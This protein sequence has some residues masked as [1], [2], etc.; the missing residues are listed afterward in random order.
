[1]TDTTD[2]PADQLRPAR[3]P[4]GRRYAVRTLL[5]LAT[6]VAVLSIVSVWANRQLLNADNWADTSTQLLADPAVKTAVSGYLIDQVYANVDVSAELARALPP[7]LK[8]LAG[9]ASGGLQN[10]AQQVTEKALGRPRVQ[11]AWKTANRLAAERFVAIAEGKSRLVTISGQTVY[12]DLGALVTQDGQRLGL[13]ASL[14]A[15]IP[16]GAGRIA[17]VNSRQASAVQDATAALRGL[18]VVLPLA[19]VLLLVL[20]VALARGRRRETL[21]A[22]GWCLV[23]AG[24]LVLVARTVAGQR[25]VDSLARTDAVVPAAQATWTIATSM[26][27]DI[28]WATIVIGIP[29]VIAAWIAGP[30]RSAH[31]LRRAA[32]PWLRERPDVTYGVAA[33]LLLLVIAWG[34]IPATRMVIPVLVMIALVA[35]GVTMLRR[36]VA[37]EFPGATV[38]GAQTAWHDR[39]AHARHAVREG[40]PRRR[41]TSVGGADGRAGNGAAPAGVAPVPVVSPAERI[42]LL[43][44]LTTLHERGVLTDAELATEKAA[45]LHPGDGTG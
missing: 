26:L 6:I 13:P 16:P 39:F 44:R 27:H 21:R 32:A 38:A 10:L 43:E 11:Q 23:L 15:K 8:P 4:R 25:V 37:L 3:L 20:A 42:A 36:Q 45:L 5:V 34:P 19:G 14:T 33:A 17:I 41:P 28:A 29:L 24:V 9:P 7:R 22:A 31:A 18:A 30:M 40:M 35:L 12:L 1:M 2:D